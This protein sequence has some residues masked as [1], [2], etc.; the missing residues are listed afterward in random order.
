[1]SITQYARAWD[2]FQGPALDKLAALAI[3]DW[4]D[5]D[6]CAVVTA[7]ELA[8]KLRVTHP[9]AVEVIGRLMKRGFLVQT[10]RHWFRIQGGE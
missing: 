9:E 5:D 8:G 4:A 7:I 10:S 1:M 3:A 2:S 6:G